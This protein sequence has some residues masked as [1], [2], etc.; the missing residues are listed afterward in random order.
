M[1]DTV[2]A[3]DAFGGGFLAWWAEHGLGR[4]SL[5]DPAA[6]RAA[7]AAAAAVASLT[8]QRPGAD[9]PWRLAS[10]PIRAGTRRPE[11]GFAERRA[12]GR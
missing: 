8:C 7:A 12:R 5:T 4:D 6:V 9:P 11:N 10:A 3:G 1:V 2:G